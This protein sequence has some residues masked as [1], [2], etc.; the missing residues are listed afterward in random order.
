[1]LLLQGTLRVYKGYNGYKEATVG[2]LR[3]GGLFGEPSP[4][5]RPAT[6]RHRGGGLR[7]PGG[8]HRQGLRRGPPQAR[9][10]L[11]HGVR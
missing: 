9:P 4:A 3:D 10:G 6:R 7:L 5:P 2:F 11:R 1:M 8:P